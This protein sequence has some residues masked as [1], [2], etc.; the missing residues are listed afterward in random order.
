MRLETTTNA[1]F[2]L[3][4]GPKEA[5]IYV[6]CNEVKFDLR[7]KILVWYIIKGYKELRY[8]PVTKEDILH[9]YQL[10]RTGH[11]MQNVTL[12]EGDLID[13]IDAFLKSR[14]LEMIANN[15]GCL[16]GMSAYT[17]E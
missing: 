9:S 1:S 8:D 15:E 5:V 7:D 16:S 10:T 6:A 3:E 4:T 13:N 14:T 2:H 17:F 11:S 12:A